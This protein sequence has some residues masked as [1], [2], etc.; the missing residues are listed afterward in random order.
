M[1]ISLV[2]LC[3]FQVLDGVFTRRAVSE[4]LVRE[5]NPLLGNAVTAWGSVVVK[6]AGAAACAVLLWLLHLRFPRIASF[7]AIFVAAFYGSVIMW[8]VSTLLRP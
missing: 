1:K 4:G 3:A 2:L 7:S 8:N 5:A 6:I